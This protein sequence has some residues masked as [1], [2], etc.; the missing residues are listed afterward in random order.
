M[1]RD[2]FLE[3][4]DGPFR[5]PKT[6]ARLKKNYSNFVYNKRTNYNIATRKNVEY[7]CFKSEVIH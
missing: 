5:T 1:A 2:N 4:N 3:K 7:K 6:F